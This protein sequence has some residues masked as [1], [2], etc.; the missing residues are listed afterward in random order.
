MKQLSTLELILLISIIRLGK[1]AY[2]VAIKKQVY[3]LTGNEMKYG[4]LYNSLDQ[5]VRKRYVVT[6]TG[7]P[8]SERGGRRKIFYSI[9]NEGNKALK[10]AKELQ[11]NLW[12]G[13][14]GYVLD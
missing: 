13:I 7:E 6:I 12:G 9:T 2:G 11:N 10:A 14:S 5:L 1:D 8:T 4:T 3:D